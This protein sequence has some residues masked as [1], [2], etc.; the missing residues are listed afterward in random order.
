VAS[1]PTPRSRRWSGSAATGANAGRQRCGNGGRYVQFDTILVE[2]FGALARLTLNRPQRANALN[3]AMLAEIGHALDALEGDAGVRAVI[4][5]GAGAAFS[6]G[7][8]LKEQLERRPVGSAQWQP[9]LRR[10][11]DTIMRF[12][13]S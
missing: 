12:W 10:D 8:D 3:Q 7:F 13:H 1:T 11:F 6:S 5:R 9:I 2:R 4:V